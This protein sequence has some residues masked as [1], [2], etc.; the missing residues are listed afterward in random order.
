MTEIGPATVVVYG[1][2][3]FQIGLV[4][5]EF[6]NAFFARSVQSKVD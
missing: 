3:S 4:G 5:D 6:G 2:R 1:E